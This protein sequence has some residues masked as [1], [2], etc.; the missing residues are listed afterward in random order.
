AAEQL[1]GAVMVNPHDIADL[2]AGILE[3]VQMDERTRTRRMKQMR[4]R[5]ATDTVSRW[6][7]NF[8]AELEHIKDN[9]E[10]IVP[11]QPV[12]QKKRTAPPPDVPAA[13]SDRAERPD[14][15]EWTDD[16]STAR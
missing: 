2:K 3:A 12:V 9:P 15:A 14:D 5:V 13:P 4:K 7:K 6:S 8:L 1:K 11:E 10:A 16:I